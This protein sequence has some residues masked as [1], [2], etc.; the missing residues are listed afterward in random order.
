MKLT[1]Y[2]VL[3][4]F[5]L[6]Q[7]AFAGQTG[8]IAGSVSDA[9]DGKPL[10]GA[11]IFLDELP[12]GAASDSDGDYIILNVAPGIYTLHA[13]MVGYREVE[14]TN[15]HV[16]LDKTTR[17]D[18]SLEPTV[19]ES[20]AIVVEAEQPLIQKDMTA[21]AS[22]ITAEE[23][24][25]IPVESMQDILQLQAGVVVDSRGGFHIRGGRAN[26]VAYMVDGVSVSDPYNGGIAV[27][28]NQDA[29][30]ELKVISGT[31]NAEYGKVMSGVVEV[32]T[33]DPEPVFNAGVTLYT[34]DYF[35][36][37]KTL[38]PNIGDISP[39]DI[40]NA[41]FHLTGPFPFLKDRVSFYISLRKYYNEGWI[42]GI[43]RFNTSDSSVFTPNAFHFE[44]TGDG[45]P[46]PM[47][48][49]DQYYANLKLIYKIK[50]NLKLDYNFLGSKKNN[51]SYNHLYKYD[52][53]GDLTHHEYGYTHILALNHAL[54]AKTFYTL[55][56]SHYNFN[57]R[58]YLYENLDDPRYQNPE[59]LRN[60]EDAYSF[61]TG[62]TNMDHF[63]RTT[64][65]TLARFDIT[66]QV[67]KTNLVKT[68]VEMKYNKIQ[69]ENREARYKGMESGIFS[70]AAFFNE[71]YYRHEPLEFSAYMQDKIE[72]QNMTVNAGLRYDYFNSRGKV[73]L[74]LRDPGN[75]YR[76]R[77]TAYRQ[78]KP[79]H[80]ISPRLGL[81][82]PISS[83]GVIHASYGY[84]FQIPD[85]QYL[86][87]NPRFAVAPGGLNT[88]MG[89]A[90][91]KPQSTVIYELGLQQEFM[92][93]FALHITG[94][95]KDVRNL[96]GTS[97]YETYIL[98][99]RYARYENRDYGN[100]KGITVSFKKQATSSDY[101]YAS[102]DYTFQIAEGNASDPNAVFYNNQANPPRQANIQVVPL[103][104]DQR[105]TVN[106]SLSFSRPGW[107]TLGLIAQFQSGLPYTPA[108]QNLEATFE[109][110]GR[111][112]FNYTVDVRFSK[113]WKPW[114][115]SLV[116]FLKIYNLFD[117]QNELTVY[118]DTGRAGYSLIGHFLGDRKAVVNTLDDWLKRPDYYSEP[119]KILLGFTFTLK[120]KP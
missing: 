44:E 90:E 74:D 28:V 12:V 13:V 16:S 113:G 59:L 64:T 96:L 105:H 22:A 120:Q 47:N 117:R 97:I 75:I 82:F 103:D 116:F 98:G 32:V 19:L 14:I 83:S 61:L 39:T 55:K 7:A 25:T 58:S 45:A 15:V 76:P 2:T 63:Y 3:T 106:A 79:Q 5:I 49:T 20:E 29:I 60:R 119:R 26:E 8:K 94:F 37:N 88:L 95:Y 65:V 89:N 38:Y 51:R 85:M 11:N 114:G 99:D 111:K 66:S 43:R 102:L 77:E 41:Q 31:F 84:F 109:N 50:P 71:G 34:G 101:L 70:S 35:S 72:L 80:Q 118:N 92:D 104:W 57:L 54:S 110:S 46:V 17:I 1:L 115:H 108:I 33:K 100:I 52:P 36:N 56:F 4:V 107:F 93:Q 18:F 21:S 87:L 24:K 73:P 48:F 42:Y 10:V 53:D 40:Y 69:V 68:G 9:T 6:A 81:A 86:Y 62:G 91:L 78:A 23:I 30:Q 67:T 27:N 112:P